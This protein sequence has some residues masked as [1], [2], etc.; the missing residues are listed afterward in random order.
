MPRIIVTE[1]QWIRKGIE[2]FEQGGIDQLVVEKWPFLWGAVRAVFIGILTIAAAT[3]D[4][5][6]RHGRNRRHN[7]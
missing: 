4:R 7:R 2:R 5:L 1:E 6:W 3:L